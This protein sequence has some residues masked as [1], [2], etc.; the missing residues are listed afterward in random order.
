M[1][2]KIL[3]EAEK[4]EARL[5]EIEQEYIALNDELSKSLGAKKATQINELIEELRR[6]INE[7]TVLLDLNRKRRQ[8]RRVSLLPV[9]RKEQ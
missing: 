7:R 8:Q 4:I 6:L 3:T 2:K 9:R 1:K 5:I